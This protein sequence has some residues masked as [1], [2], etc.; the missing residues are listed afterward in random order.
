MHG[1]SIGEVEKITGIK[2]HVLRYWEENV[3]LLQPQK[4]SSGRRVYTKRDMD[5]IFKLDYLINK[6]KYTLEGASKEL[7]HQADL[8]N[9]KP[10]II[11]E[12]RS[13]LLDIYEII[14]R[15]SEK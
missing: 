10:V 13:S 8:S 9:E 7:L 15:S 14:K 1:F 2:A 4:D 5:F 11:S 6:K 3:P 12:I